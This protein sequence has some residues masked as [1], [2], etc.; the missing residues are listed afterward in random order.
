MKWYKRTII[1]ALGLGIEVCFAVLSGLLIKA[2]GEWVASL[3]LPYFAPR[4]PLFFGMLSGV[5]HIFSSLALAA[6]AERKDLL[7][8]GIFL[9]ITE[10]ISELVF[11]AFFFELTYEISSFFIATGCMLLSVICLWIYSKKS[12]SAAL[13]KLPV[14]HIK[15]YLW[16]IVYCILTLNFT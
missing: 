13:L 11:L 1:L 8:K 9:T 6:Y 4:S 14:V 10:G 5:M 15:I 7:P 2:N 16:M 3:I 12:D